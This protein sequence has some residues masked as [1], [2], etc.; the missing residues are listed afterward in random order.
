[1]EVCTSLYSMLNNTNE[2]LEIPHWFSTFM[3]KT[4]FNSTRKDVR[5][6]N[7]NKDYKSPCLRSQITTWFHCHRNQTTLWFGFSGNLDFSMSP[8]RVMVA[9]L[10]TV[11]QPSLRSSSV[12]H[13]HLNQFDMKILSLYTYE[14]CKNVDQLHIKNDCHIM[15]I[16]HIRWSLSSETVV[17]DIRWRRSSEIVV[18]DGRRKR[19][20][21][22]VVGD[23]CQIFYALTHFV[24]S[25]CRVHLLQRLQNYHGLSQIWSLL[26]RE[27]LQQP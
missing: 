20:S 23:S 26:Q 5:L 12:K 22:T 21:E 8:F 13:S 10:H 7:I 16:G 9:V 27:L 2:V 24:P 19:S 3:S 11:A 6:C 1:M 4:F 14:T 17:G 15:V 18:G 25:A